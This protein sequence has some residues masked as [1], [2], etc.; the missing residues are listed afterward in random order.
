MRQATIE[1]AEVPN[2][3]NGKLPSL[4]TYETHLHEEKLIGAPH[5]RC[6][7][8]EYLVKDRAIPREV[9]NHHEEYGKSE[10]WGDCVVEDYIRGVRRVRNE[11]S[12]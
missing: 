9:V 11:T 7:S 5:P 4:R 8:E 6:E 2:A 1:S 12:R 3:T 10:N